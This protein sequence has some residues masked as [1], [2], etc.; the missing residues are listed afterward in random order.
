MKRIWNL[1]LNTIL[2]DPF[3]VIE[4]QSVS[5]FLISEEDAAK[6]SALQQLIAIKHAVLVPEDFVPPTLKS[7]S[8]A[9]D[10][11]FVKSDSAEGS[12]VV[13]PQTVSIEAEVDLKEGMESRS[14]EIF[15]TIEDEDLHDEKYLKSRGIE[16]VED[17]NP[18]FSS[19][20]E[21]ELADETVEKS[22]QA[23]TEV[24]TMKMGPEA[25]PVV[26]EE[27]SSF[28][29]SKGDVFPSGVEMKSSE[30]VQSNIAQ[31][32]KILKELGSSIEKEE[33]LKKL[34][35]EVQEAIKKF[36]SYEDYLKKIWIANSSSKELLN[37]M[38]F[39][40]ADHS[41][42]TSLIDQRL[43]ELE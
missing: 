24:V 37:F 38:K 6:N 23:S 15:E 40:F 12:S 42:I 22:I 10:I 7:V 20:Q 26:P 3:G 39:Y 5:R 11:V 27:D 36:A 8:H 17:Q 13:A 41:I 1:S 25:E 29:F 19:R 32:S 16:P 18:E 31:L 33:A 21:V 9:S 30:V 43:Q 28:V 4:P 34:P 14:G 2:L 35:D